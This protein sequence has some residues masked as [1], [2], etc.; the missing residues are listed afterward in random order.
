MGHTIAD[1]RRATL[2]LLVGV[3]ILTAD[4]REP[5]NAASSQLVA[6]ITAPA[7]GTKLRSGQTMTVDVTVRAPSDVAVSWTVVLQH[8]S[9]APRT[10]A[11]GDGV[12]ENQGVAELAAADLVRGEQYTVTL[13]VSD[14]A[15]GDAEAD[16]PF[17]VPDPL[18]ELIPLEP[19]NHNR[20]SPLDTY[21]LDATGGLVGTSGDASFP[22][23]LVLLSRSTGQRR[24]VSVYTGDNS[25]VW[26]TA[27]ATRLY[28]LGYT[29]VSDGARFGIG[30][31]DLSTATL[32]F[33][34]SSGSDWYTVSGNGHQVAYQGAGPGG[35][36]YL[37]WDEDTQQIQQLTN[38]PDAIL[39]SDTDCTSF[40]GTGP[41]IS[42]DGSEVVFITSS[43][44]GIEPADPLI[45]CRV[46]VYEVG[47]QSLRQVTAFSADSRVGFP[48]LS[49][50]GRWLSL[51]HGAPTPDGDRNY[52]ALIDVAT[53]VV[54]D[55]VVDLNG[56]SSYEAEITGDGTG[57][58]IS[59]QG[60]LDPRV[61]NADGNF[62][63]FYYDLQSQQFHQITETVGGLD[64]P[65]DGCA[66]YDPRVSDHGEVVLFGGFYLL[67]GIGGTC[68]FDT[69]QRTESTEFSFEFTRAVRK[70]PGNHG[71]VLAAV[72]D[73]RV[74]AG[75]TLTVNFAADDPDGDP[76]TFFAQV[77]GGIDVPPDS[78]ITD[79]HDGTATFMWPTRPEHAGTY[80]LRV[81]AF[82]E[83]GD[84]VFQDVMIEVAAG[85][86]TETPS[87]IAT[88]T[89]TP[90]TGTCAP[91]PG[92]IPP[93]CAAHCEPCPTIRAGCNAQ[94]CVRCIENPVC[95]LGEICAPQ[96]ELGC[97]ACATVTPPPTT[98]TLVQPTVSP[99]A[100]TDFTI[101][102]C[103]A[104]FPDEPCGQIGFTVQLDPL[105]VTAPSPDF[106]F[107][108]LP[109][110]DYVLSVHPG[111]NPFGCWPQ[112]PVTIA[113]HD[114]YVDIPLLANTPTPTPTPTTTIGE[115]V[116]DCNGDGVVTINE[117]IVG[118]TIE[119]GGASASACPAFDC[120]CGS[121]LAML[122]GICCAIDAVNNAL[123]GCP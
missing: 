97:C 121:P 7:P 94:P 21:F 56:H 77:Q 64:G 29:P 50:N 78:V 93:Y 92:G 54:R 41:L 117:L 111:C 34:A 43:T 91:T 12:L 100:R 95:G 22:E 89:P 36:G 27:D 73:Q 122:P 11:S 114:V 52:P 24:K 48:W 40:Q 96:G 68:F 19:G 83:G 60:D 15:G 86:A 37:L 105:G 103:V 80:V 76:I 99:T 71:P 20:Y 120:D 88:P 13:S 16:A 90:M 57:I 26:L 66:P 65:I 109:P 31:L 47:A 46:Y 5:A 110:G 35:P 74:V 33:A 59:N 28:S 63:L 4:Y 39:H 14:G 119:L 106:R 81:A 49:A 25:G 118:V 1:V 55:P 23:D 18:Y 10:L 9:D 58:V 84:D 2:V 112:V 108:N 42:R 107:T 44:L 82:D 32:Q 8:A 87:A 70:R 51:V 53:G 69:P 79:H 3:S 102:G 67:S 85:P 45:G 104:E 75:E 115:C 101:D 116:G 61:G 6:V 17:L 62:E 123:S 30:Y 98:T 113:D 38:S 72:P